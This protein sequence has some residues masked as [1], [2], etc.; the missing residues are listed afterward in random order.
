MAVIDSG[1][2]TREGARLLP[3]S[4]P[5]AKTNSLCHQYP[6]PPDH[7]RQR[8]VCAGRNDVCGNLPRALT[9]RELPQG[10]SLGGHLI[11]EVK[12]VPPTLL[13]DGE[14]KSIS[15]SAC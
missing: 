11:D 3:P 7:F 6:R 14:M 2:S 10:I 9:A 15:A 4:A 13:V 1:G 5:D 8:R 12:I